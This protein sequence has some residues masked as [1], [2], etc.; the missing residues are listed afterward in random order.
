MVVPLF[1]AFFLCREKDATRSSG[2]WARRRQSRPSHSCARKSR[3]FSCPSASCVPHVHLMETLV[4]NLIPLAHHTNLYVFFLELLTALDTSSHC[5]FINW[6][7][8]MY[9]QI[10]LRKSLLISGSVPTTRLR[11]SSGY[12]FFIIYHLFQLDI[13]VH[14]Y[15]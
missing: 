15:Q 1:R 4:T 13:K 8:L 5:H 2:G 10:F 3:Q 11:F 7:S 12:I 6:L 9:D 14:K